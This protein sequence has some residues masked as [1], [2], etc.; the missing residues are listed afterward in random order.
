MRVEFVHQMPSIKDAFQT[1]LKLNEEA[2]QLVCGSGIILLVRQDGSLDWYSYV[3]LN[4]PSGED[5]SRILGV[6]DKA[7]TRTDRRVD[8]LSVKSAFW[9][10][11]LRRRCKNSG[12]S[13][14]ASQRLGLLTT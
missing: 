7:G 14:T 4:D 10:M 13:R 11:F 3:D 1:V 9:R 12:G 5:K 6:M 2:P 8:D